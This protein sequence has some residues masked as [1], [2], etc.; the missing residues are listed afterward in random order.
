[1]R[2]LGGTIDV[3][4]RLGQGTTFFVRLPRQMNIELSETDQK[5]ILKMLKTNK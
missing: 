1:M 4:S 5:S 3:E 2:K